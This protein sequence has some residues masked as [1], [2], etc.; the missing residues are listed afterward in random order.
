[1]GNAAVDLEWLCDG[2]DQKI[3]HD[4]ERF[5]CWLKFQYEL[6]LHFLAVM[7]EC[8]DYLEISTVNKSIIE[9]DL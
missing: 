9:I 5:L 1:M 8:H 7:S 6:M 4:I 2:E 3:L